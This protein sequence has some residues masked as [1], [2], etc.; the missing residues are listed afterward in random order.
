MTAC[1][2]SRPQIRREWS[3]RRDST[4]KYPTPTHPPSR[5]SCDA[6]SST[7]YDQPSPAPK[8]IAKF[9]RKIGRICHQLQLLLDDLRLLHCVRRLFARGQ[10]EIRS[11]SRSSSEQLLA[12]NDHSHGRICNSATTD[13]LSK[14]VHSRSDSLLE[15]P[16]YAAHTTHTLYHAE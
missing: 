2:S 11:Y 14:D 10:R 3:R 5:R 15:D 16:L 9:R 4:S 12:C 1:R 8:Q 13:A 6:S 7:L